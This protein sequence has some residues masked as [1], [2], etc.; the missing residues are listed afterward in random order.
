MLRQLQP[1]RA[2]KRKAG[3]ATE[4]PACEPRMPPPK[5]AKKAAASAA[6]AAAE[7]WDRASRPVYKDL[8]H[9]YQLVKEESARLEAVWRCVASKKVRAGLLCLG[10]TG[11]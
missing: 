9:K 3:D 6:T 5:S 8:P 11:G 7:R 2:P 4:A 1:P 10:G